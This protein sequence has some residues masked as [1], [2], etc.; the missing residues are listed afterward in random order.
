[1]SIVRTPWST[2][3]SRR[4]FWF[5]LPSLTA[6]AATQIVPNTANAQILE[7]FALRGEAGAGTMFPTHQRNVLGY[8]S[9]NFQGT[10]R[11]GFTLFEPLVLQISALNGWYPSRPQPEGRLT[12][13]E[14]GL[15]VE[16][17]IGSVGRLFVDANAGVGFTGGLVRTA[18]DAGLGF[19][20]AV[21]S[22]VHVGPVVR[23]GHV[24]QDPTDVFPQDAQF[25]WGGLSL[26]LRAPVT[27]PVV[28]P[29]HRE[30]PPPPPDSDR[31]GVLDPMDLCLNE[32]AGQHPD[33]ERPGCPLRDSDNDGVFDHQDQCPTTPRG[34]HPDPERPGCPDGDD[35][36]DT[37]LNHSDQCRTE[38]QGPSPDP[39]RP[40]CPAP[41]RD[42][43]T[44][45]DPVDHCPDQPGAPHPDPNRH[46]CPG[47]VRVEPTQIRI[48]QQVFFATNRDRILPRSYPVLQAVADALQA[49]PQIRRV[50]I[51]GHTDNVGNDQRNLDLSQR[52]AQSVMRW[53]I[54]HGIDP[55]RLEAHG[56][57]ETRPIQ[58]NDTPAGRAANRRVEF[59]I[60]DPA[61]PTAEGAG[62]SGSRTP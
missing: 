10:G 50:S 46:G 31:D 27:E 22:F 57:G 42:G 16:P 18:F 14:G 51:E 17:K 61:P 29:V 36:N 41:D 47:L 52:R 13:Y 35:D 45:P 25:W 44:I 30:P 1:M 20:F 9:V 53:L 59:R 4:V 49:M 38:P 26:A 60:L 40:G 62:S 54:E 3:R 56:Y 11:L 21:A 19:E 2:L 28:T 33:P 15:R 34:E 37:V 43:D 7:R 12:V 23:Y 5:A 48:L 8:D 24:I 6:I 32:P 55:S 58:S 39:A